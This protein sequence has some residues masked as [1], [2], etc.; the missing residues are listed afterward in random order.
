MQQPPSEHGVY[1]IEMSNFC[2]GL[3]AFIMVCLCLRS[4]YDLL[5]LF[6]SL[7]I[8][9]TFLSIVL[10]LCSVFPLSY[11][12]QTNIARPHSFYFYSR[13]LTRARHQTEYQAIARTDPLTEP[14]L[15]YPPII[16]LLLNSPVHPLVL[17]WFDSPAVVD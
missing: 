11:T 4:N 7:V 16:S 5:L 9:S 6:R 12:V 15:P 13:T 8:G 2:D 10:R 1:I 17:H 3:L 14:F